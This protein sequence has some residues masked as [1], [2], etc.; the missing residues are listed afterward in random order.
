MQVRELKEGP[1]KVKGQVVALAE[2]LRSPM[3]KKPCVYYQ[4]LVTGNKSAFMR[5]ST[6]V[7]DSGSIPCAVDDGTGAVMLNFVDTK[8]DL[9][10]DRHTWTGLLYPDSPDVVR[11][12]E[13]RYGVRGHGVSTSYRETIL[14]EGDTIIVLGHVRTNKDGGWVFTKGRKRPLIIWDRTEEQLAS[15]YRRWLKQCWIAAAA[16][17]LGGI[18]LIILAFLGIN[19]SWSA[20]HG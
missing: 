9:A 13:E 8:P 7:H 19:V 11:F 20:R 18:L 12:V 14:E 17:L 15:R 16:A 6:L 2:T 10:V 5:P 1:V 4:F 3:L